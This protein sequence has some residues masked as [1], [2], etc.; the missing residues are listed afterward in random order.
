MIGAPVLQS[1]RLLEYLFLCFDLRAMV[2]L[3]EHV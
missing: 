2:T 1:V 3:K